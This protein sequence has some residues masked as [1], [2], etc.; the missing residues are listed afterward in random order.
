MKLLTKKEQEVLTRN[1]EI[2]A[3]ILN[4]LANL[5]EPGK[6]EKQIEDQAVTMIKEKSGEAAFLGYPGGS[7]PYPSATC[8]SVNE[9]VVHSPP[10]SYKFKPGDLVSVDLGFKKDG[11][12]TDACF[13]VLLE[14]SDKKQLEEDERLLLTT[15][16]ALRRA[17]EISKPGAYTGDIGNIINKIASEAGLKTVKCLTGHGIGRKLHQEPAI[18]NYGKKGTGIKLKPGMAIAIEPIISNGSEEVISRVDDQFSLYTKDGSKTA[19]FED[20]ILITE[21]G[22]KVLTKQIFCDNVIKDIK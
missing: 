5:V 8:I 13:S 6:S 19:H 15:K 11:L 7:K 17:I 4:K 1:G 14:G 21:T 3:E 18:Y 22:N 9:E 20:T 2:L 12:Y 10:T 16:E